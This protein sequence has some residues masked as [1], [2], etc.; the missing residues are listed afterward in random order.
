MPTHNK[1][2]ADA[3]GAYDDEFRAILQ[4]DPD[5]QRVIHGVWGDGPRPGD[6]PKN[7]E[8]AN[9]QASKQITQILKSKGIELPDRTFVNPRT[10]SIEGHRGWSGLNGWQKAAIIAAAGA[11]GVGAGMALAGGGAAAGAAGSGAGLSVASGVPAG[12]AG[13]GATGITAGGAAVGGG[14]TLASMAT[15]AGLNAARTKLTG[16]SWRDALISGGMGAAGGAG[17]GGGNM[18]WG[19]TLS[20]FGKDIAKDAGGSLMQQLLSGD[21][22]A[23]AGKG[24]GAIG[25]TAAHNRGVALDAMMAGDQMTLAA[26]Q[27]ERAAQA[28]AMKRLQSASYIKNGG[29]DYKPSVSVSGKPLGQFDFGVRPSSAA[30]IEGATTVEGQLLNRLKNPIKL[31]DYDSK[32]EPGRMET[33]ANYASPALTTLGAARGAGRYQMPQAAAAT[34]TPAAPS[35]GTPTEIAQSGPPPTVRFNP[36]TPRPAGNPYE[37]L[38]LFGTSE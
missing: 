20:N 6:T 7:L 21:S 5:I 37:R 4:N 14:S 16:G 23:A 35:A 19:S 29:A 2:G 32:M 15:N 28:D 38:N 24:I 11:T 36:L 17:G 10:G 3:A 13:V 33:L 34:P 9:D 27:N 8:K 18:S 30:A 25:Q 12:M 1:A 31:R 22:L 26:D